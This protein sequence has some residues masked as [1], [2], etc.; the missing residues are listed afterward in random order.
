[1]ANYPLANNIC[2]FNNPGIYLITV[3]NNLLPLLIKL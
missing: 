3:V 2:A 1:M